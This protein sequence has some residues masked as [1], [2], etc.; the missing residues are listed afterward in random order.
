MLAAKAGADYAEKA[1]QP[2][3]DLNWVLERIHP[4]RTEQRGQ[5][6]EMA[7]FRWDEHAMR[8]HRAKT[9][10]AEIADTAFK[11][12]TVTTAEGAQ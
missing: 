7:A 12:A 2:A 5:G 9:V 10:L 8:I 11:T 1:E 3:V 4:V 6:F